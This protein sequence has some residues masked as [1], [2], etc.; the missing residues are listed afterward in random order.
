M[1]F[2]YLVARV[3]ASAAPV[4]PLGISARLTL[5]L[6]A[7]ALLAAA[8]NM[9]A[10]DS[11]TIIRM[12][13]RSPVPAVPAPA[14]APPTA[15]NPAAGD[16]MRV[17]ALA[18]ALDRYERATQLRADIDSA[19][20]ES[21]Y[22]A[23]SN[24]LQRW[25]RGNAAGTPA[26]NAPML[27]VA[28]RV[29]DYLDLGQALLHV[30]DRRRQARMEYSQLSRSISD[31]MQHALNGAWTLF[32]RVLARQSLLQMKSSLDT[33][34]EHSGAI[35]SGDPLSTQDLSLI[36]RSETAFATAL[37]ANQERLTKSEGTEWMRGV[38]QNFNALVALRVSLAS[39]NSQ[40]EAAAQ[41]FLDDGLALS[42][43]TLSTAAQATAAPSIAMVAAARPVPPAVSQT[44][45]L[46]ARESLSATPPLSGDTGAE[47]LLKSS[48]GKAR[49]LVQAVTAAVVLLIAVISIFTVRSVITPVRRILQAFGQLADGESNI[50][51]ARGGLRELDTLAGAFNEMSAS[52]TMAQQASRYHQE[53]LE[54]KVSERTHKLQQ[55]AQ[56]DPLTSLP[57]RRHL[58][59]LL[60]TAIERAA[61]ENRFVGVYFLD[62]DNFKNFND[63]LGHVF[64]DRVLMSVAN[65]L[66]E[67]ADG[68]GFVARL[69]GD[70]FTFVY[71]NA[72]SVQ[73]I[74]DVGWDLVRAFHKLVSVD[75]REL[76]VSVSVGAS[77]FPVHESDAEGLLRA[78][79]S[80]LFRAKELGRSQLAMFTPQLIETA[81]VRF[82]IEQG[83]RR[84]IERGEF[85]LVYQ[86]EVNLATLETGLVEALLRWRLPDG[87]LIRPG[88]F[89]AVAEQSGLIS[90]ISTW[91]LRTAIA[92]ASR[93]HHGGWP[94]ARVAIN[95]SPR[96]LLDHRFIDQLLAL[97]LEY[98]LPTKCIELELTETVLQT[99]AATIAA[100]RVL[101]AHDVRIALDDFGTGYSSLTSLEQLPLSRIKLDRGL[102]ASIDTSSRAAAI[103]RAIIDLCAGLGLEVTAE[104]IERPQQLAWLLGNCGM[105]LQGY[106]LSDAVP[107]AEVLQVKASL[108]GK[109]QDLLLSLPDKPQLS[110]IEPSDA[111]IRA[112]R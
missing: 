77:I 58:S 35:L 16:A 5:S 4:F 9:I 39:L 56:Q 66:E 100:L 38:Q 67:M 25:S 40:H 96:Q 87:R 109:V 55:L 36:L 6:A 92:D 93:W 64:G 2:R 85:E 42:T 75:Q 52:L 63:S 79:D 78:A 65:R 31:R 106:L 29:M 41:K 111:R 8:A 107:F 103:A 105:F 33:I 81:A 43:A 108:V 84:A 48:D 74:N 15:M 34:R 70:E 11:V 49:N 46:P 98:R 59:A 94:D 68:L 24:A 26:A 60:N 101:Q 71:E 73:A 102:I 13:T 17:I 30:A 72:A 22:L 14:A 89:L 82:T 112:N 44:S 61:R 80:A 1:D 37:K 62:I 27:A 86:P 53:R 32:G 23:A 69:G 3:K 88:E 47:T 90:E 12:V 76:S 18:I 83:L 57:N 99:G 95:I 50:E 19:S 45:F 28:P 110:A 21:E 10:R 7:V 104:G 91:V 20:A 54:E 51:V 97:L